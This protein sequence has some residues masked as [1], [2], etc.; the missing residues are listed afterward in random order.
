MR[1]Y[2]SQHI[3]QEDVGGAYIL[4]LARQ[5]DS[6]PPGCA[7]PNV[8]ACDCLK[9]LLDRGYLSSIRKSA[10]DNIEF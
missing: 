6:L 2:R 1:I 5:N 9:I 7:T 10:T 8:L 4:V 3:I